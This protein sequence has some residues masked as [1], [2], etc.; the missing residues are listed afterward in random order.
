MTLWGGV[1]AALKIKNGY[2][3]CCFVIYVLK[4]LKS[5]IFYEKCFNFGSKDQLYKIEGL[6]LNR[7]SNQLRIKISEQWKEARLILQSRI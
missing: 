4:I 5:L 3:Q 2:R 1:L 7:G 6:Y